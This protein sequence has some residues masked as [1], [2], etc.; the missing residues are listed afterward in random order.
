MTRAS[1]TC[2]LALLRRREFSFKD[3]LLLSFIIFSF[4]VSTFRADVK[5]RSCSGSLCCSS[6]L[7]FTQSIIIPITQQKTQNYHN[8]TLEANNS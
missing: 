7:Q 2:I 3:L 6:T 4:S 8:L 1:H 5:S